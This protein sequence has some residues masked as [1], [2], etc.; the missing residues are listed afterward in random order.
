MWPPPPGRTVP[1]LRLCRLT[2]DA[3]LPSGPFP[4]HLVLSLVSEDR[5]RRRAGREHLMTVLA[6]EDNPCMPR[7]TSLPRVSPDSTVP[8]AC[9]VGMRRCRPRRAERVPGAGCSLP[10]NPGV[11]T[12]R[13]GGESEQAAPRFRVSYP[14]RLARAARR[15]RRS[16]AVATAHALTAPRTREGRWVPPEVTCPARPP[17]FRPRAL[18]PAPARCCPVPGAPGTDT[19]LRL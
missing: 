7:D 14:T 10:S 4:D 13:R 2:S 1:G 9:P 16:R 3:S 18:S 19:A 11:R 5:L 15:D 17:R 8:P 12:S 6:A